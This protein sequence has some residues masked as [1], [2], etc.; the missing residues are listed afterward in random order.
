MKPE[1]ETP[2]CPVCKVP[3]NDVWENT[4]FEPP[5]PTHWEIIDWECPQCGYK[6]SEE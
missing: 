1:P 4:G 2:M 3:L 5:D 6:L